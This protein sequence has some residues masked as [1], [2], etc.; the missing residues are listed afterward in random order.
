MNKSKLYREL[1]RHV[2][3]HNYEAT[4]DGIL[5]PQAGLVAQGVFEVE[6]LTR[7]DGNTVAPNLVVTQG[8][9]HVVAVILGGTSA[10]STWYLAPFA[11]NVTP[12]AG[13]DASNFDSN[14]TEFTNYDE[15]SR[16]AFVDGGASGGAID[17]LAARAE[18]TIGSG[19]QDTLHGVGLLSS[20]MKG[21]N[22]GVL[23]S[24]ARLPSARTN[25]R[26]A[27][28]IALGYTYTV[29]DAS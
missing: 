20:A 9:N 21:G 8:L 11:G 14:A 4:S 12:T 2:R 7:G 5:F 29:T 17:N 24:A 26:V 16:Q 13:W 22:Q 23:M 15:A 25:L 6:N 28:V 1:G 18:I 3:N 27:D 19:P 10:V